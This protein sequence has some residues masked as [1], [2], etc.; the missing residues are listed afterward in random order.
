MINNN[1]LDVKKET[2]ESTFSDL[3]IPGNTH[4]LQSL[5]GGVFD[6]VCNIW[7]FVPDMRIIISPALSTNTNIYI[8]DFIL[9]KILYIADR[10]EHQLSYIFMA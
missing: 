2:D 9:Y 10:M 1:N 8:S 7:W 5:V 3:F 6:C 4:R